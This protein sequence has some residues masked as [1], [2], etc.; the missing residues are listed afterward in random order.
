MLTPLTS[1][2]HFGFQKQTKL[3][4]LKECGESYLDSEP[5]ECRLTDLFF[6]PRG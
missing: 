6:C 3:G 4:N 5:C 1:N 2:M